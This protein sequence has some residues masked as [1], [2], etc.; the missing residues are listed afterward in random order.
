[1]IGFVHLEN[2][3]AIGTILMLDCVQY[4]NLLMLS[5]RDVKL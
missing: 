1:M 4:V 3:S 2:K 5:I